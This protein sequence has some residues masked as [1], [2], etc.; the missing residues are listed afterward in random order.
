MKRKIRMMGGRLPLDVL[1]G[2]SDN[3]K[4]AGNFMKDDSMN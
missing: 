1:A 4:S 2:G 3:D